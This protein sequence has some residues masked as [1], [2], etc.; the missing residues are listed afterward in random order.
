MRDHFNF[1]RATMIVSEIL[2]C[3]LLSIYTLVSLELG[4]PSLIL[5]IGYSEQMQIPFPVTE[6]LNLGRKGTRIH[7][8][9][10]QDGLLFQ[11]TAKLNA[12]SC[13]L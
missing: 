11:A 4:T 10:K 6:H 3:C 7:K 8:Q 1:K 12:P 2:Q 9:S 13:D 5:N